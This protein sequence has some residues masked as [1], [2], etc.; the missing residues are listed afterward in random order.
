MTRERV[1]GFLFGI[2]IG[3]AIG[4]FLKSQGDEKASERALGARPADP[5]SSLRLH[6]VGSAAHRHPS[7]A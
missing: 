3:T 7:P 4:F 6:P 1:A 2:S 5:E